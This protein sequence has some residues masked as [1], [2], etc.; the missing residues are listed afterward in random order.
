MRHYLMKF[1]PKTEHVD[2]YDI[3]RFKLTW[4]IC[5][6]LTISL[7]IFAL[8]LFY[9]N[10]TT[11]GPTLIGATLTAL[12]L[13]IMYKTKEFW[14]AGF[15]FSTLGAVMCQYTLIFFPKEYHFVDTMWVMI[16]VLYSYFTLGRLW[17]NIIFL[18]NLL[19]IVYYLQF[20]LNSNLNQL[21]ILQ[22]GELMA[23]SINF[24][25]SGLVISYLIYQFLKTTQFAEKQYKN[26]TTELQN[27]N[28]KVENQNV[29]KTVMLKEIHHR[30]KNNLQ[31]ITS[32]LRLQSK[33][34]DDPL[35]IELFK[36]A[37]NRVSAMSLIHDKM[38]QTEDLSK[39]NLENYLNSLLEGMLSSYSVQKP[40]QASI[41]SEVDK[42]SNESL[43]PIALI[44]N[45]LVANSLKHAFIKKSKGIIEIVISKE[46]EKIVMNYSD[47]GTWLEKQKNSSFGLEL[48]DSLTEQ[49]EGSFTRTTEDGTKY[50][51]VLPDNL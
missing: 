6:Y 3:A 31:V 20:V 5:L 17:G 46:K 37:M 7:P 47:N 49:M 9:F 14:V 50:K 24:F 8:I 33:D 42:I 43:V 27:K 1:I 45:E 4:N 38:Y 11:V 15:L 34:I 10:Q 25:I 35:T 48:I 23:L 36:D 2:F 22:Q 28:L 19:G 40:I 30:V 26:L 18:L 39:I 13:F 32:L 44:F 41:K 21:D 51:F 29:E 12:I 16:I